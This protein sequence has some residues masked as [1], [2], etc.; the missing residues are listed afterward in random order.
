MTNVNDTDRDVRD[1]PLTLRE[2]TDSINRLRRNKSPG[3]DGVTS[4]FY[5]VFVE[6]VAP[7]L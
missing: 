2:T 4:E 6:Q 7:F 3:V 1:A 5:R